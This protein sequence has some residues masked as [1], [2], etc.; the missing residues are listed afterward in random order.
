MA[1]YDDIVFPTS[2]SANN[3][4]GTRRR[5]TEVG[6]TQSGSEQ[7]TVVWMDSL[8]TYEAGLV[9]RLA[10]EWILIDGLFE[11]CEGQAHGFRLKDATDYSVSLAQ[12]YPGSLDPADGSVIT[13]G[14]GFGMPILQAVKRYAYGSRY[15]YRKLTKLV[16]GSV[17]VTRNGTPVVVGAG[18][19]EIAID[20]DTGQ[21][22]FVADATRAVTGVTVG[23]T[24]QVQLATAMTGTVVTD[25]IYLTGLGGADAALLNGLSHE[26]TTIVGTTYT[27]ATDTAGKTITAGG[28]AYLYPQ[29][30][31]VIAMSAQFHVPVRFATDE[32][33]W[34]VVAGHP[35]NVLI[36]SG[37]IP[38]VEI[39]L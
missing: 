8:R 32:L 36:E 18:A 5:L 21:I 4:S 6:V 30:D 38:L 31:D 16:S 33:P 9:A 7:R 28:N 10:S 34:T 14:V 2:I 12:G 20:V 1:F 15:H 35:T 26:V 27:L 3:F 25:R 24:T 29:A 23:A 19:G 39:R 11:I 37:S 17:S 22:T 13:P